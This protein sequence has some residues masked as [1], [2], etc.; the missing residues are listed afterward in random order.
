VKKIKPDGS[1]TIYVGGL[2]EGLDK[3]DPAVDKTSGGAVTQTRTYYPAA[4]AMRIGST[5]YYVLKD[6]LGSASVVTNSSGTVVGEDRFYPYGETRFTT[7][8]M[9]TDKLFTGQREMTGLGIYHYGARF[10]SPKLGRFLS[11]D[12]IVPGAG[13]PQAFNRYAYVL[14]NP[15]RYTDPTGHGQCQTQEDCNDM[16]TTPMGTGGSGG[17]NNNNGGGGGDPHDDDDLDPNPKGLSAPKPEVIGPM[18][19]SGPCIGEPVAAGNYLGGYCGGGGG[20]SLNAVNFVGGDGE[21]VGSVCSFTGGGVSLTYA[22]SY[23]VLLYDNLM[24][25]ILHENYYIPGRDIPQMENATF[26]GSTLLSELNNGQHVETNL[27]DFIPGN[28]AH[29]SLTSREIRINYFGKENFPTQLVVRLTFGAENIG[30]NQVYYQLPYVS[31]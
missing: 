14:G 15:L 2:Y 18:N 24:V 16:G 28:V 6:H 8:T 31:P 25:V 4:G 7:G 9:F 23:D 21:C 30:G 20:L 11:A 17:S 29:Q 3:L 10:Y 27:G 5:L 13:N 12:T 1:K 19:Y 26:G 22:A